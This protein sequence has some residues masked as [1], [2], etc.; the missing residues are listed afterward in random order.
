MSSASAPA[1]P[2]TKVGG[3]KCAHD[4]DDANDSGQDSGSNRST[5]QPGPH[6]KKARANTNNCEESEECGASQ[7]T[8]G[9]AN[10]EKQKARAKD[11]KPATEATGGVARVKV[12]LQAHVQLLCLALT[13]DIVPQVPTTQEIFDF[14]MRVLA[15]SNPQALLEQSFVQVNPHSEFKYDNQRSTYREV[16]WIPH[17]Q[18][19]VSHFAKCL[20]KPTV[21]LDWFDPD[22]FNQLPP[23]IRYRYHDSSIALPSKSETSG[24]DWQK[25]KNKPFMQKYGNKVQALYNIPTDEEMEG[26]NAEGD[27][28]DWEGESDDEQEGGSGG[29]EAG[30]ADEDGK[31]M[32]E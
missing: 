30:E 21:A 6:T 7:Q 8:L 9:S 28:I 27:N 3:M 1:T 4:L 10:K 11:D 20:L 22:Q 17:P 18:N 12:A 25:M 24:N 5:P 23:H 15:N 2:P 31:A 13:A 16:S 19:K 32:E 26:E 29:G 14:E